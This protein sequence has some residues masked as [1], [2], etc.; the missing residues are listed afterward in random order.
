[1]AEA[2]FASD[3]TRN[4]P[5][6]LPVRSPSPDTKASNKLHRTISP[7]IEVRNQQQSSPKSMYASRRTN[8]EYETLHR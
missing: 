2:S 3:H 7:S 1:M 4:F 5:S 6:S 8:E